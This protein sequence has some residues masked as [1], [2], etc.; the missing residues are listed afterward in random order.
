MTSL[1]NWL[2]LPNWLQQNQVGTVNSEI[3]WSA[4]PTPFLNFL[5]QNS[6]SGVYVMGVMPNWGGVICSSV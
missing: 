4:A 5:Q 2:G 1:R 6:A 3:N